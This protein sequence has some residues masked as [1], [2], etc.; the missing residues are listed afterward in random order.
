MD[1]EAELAAVSASGYRAIQITAPY[2]SAG[3]YPWWGLRPYDY[4]GVNE[5]LDGTME[6]FKRL[7]DK[8]HEYGLR[9]LLFLN[10]GYADVTS[11]L[12]KKACQD[13]RAGIFSGERELFLWSDS[14]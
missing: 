14:K 4:F 7:V 11:P 1:I 6:D 3:F 8:C 5:V 9:V 12:W 2:K 13:K 10:L